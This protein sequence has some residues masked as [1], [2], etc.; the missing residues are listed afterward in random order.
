MKKKFL[1]LALCGAMVLSMTACGEEAQKTVE[2]A[3][4]TAESVAADVQE[5]V[6]AVRPLLSL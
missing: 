5:S 2:E 3:A 4:N 6:A 1:A